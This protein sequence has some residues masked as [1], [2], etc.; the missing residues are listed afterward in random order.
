MQ[1]LLVSIRGKN[2]AIEAVRGGAHIADAEYPMSALGTQY[3]LNI[4]AIRTSIP[5]DIPVSTNIGEKQFVWSTAAQA[6]LGVALAGADIIKVGLAELEP[7]GAIKVMYRVV[8]N[9]KWWFNQKNLIATFFADDD[10]RKFVDPVGEA[11]LIADEAGADGVL[12][13]TFDKDKGR[14]ILDYLST[15]DIVSFVDL[16]H[17]TGV[18]AWIAGSITKEQLPALWQAGVDVICVRGAACEKGKKRMG[19]VKAGIVAELLKTMP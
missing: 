5:K 18:E 3:P 14:G 8:K 13:D 7:D 10:M 11:P 4:Q 1:H 2:E 15:A 17:K 12:I 19:N 16:C 9:V 6:A